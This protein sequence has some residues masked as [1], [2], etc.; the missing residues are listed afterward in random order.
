MASWNPA[1]MPNTAADS[2]PEPDTSESTSSLG[3]HDETLNPQSLV[4]N[5]VSHDLILD[6][7]NSHLHNHSRGATQSPTKDRQPPVEH[8]L[9]QASVASSS[10]E[11]HR[12]QQTDVAPTPA[13]AS[14]NNQSDADAPAPLANVAKH[15]SSVSFA[16]TVSHDVN[17]LDE[18]DGDWDLGQ[19]DTE[20]FNSLMPENERTNSFPPVPPQADSHQSELAD[21]PLAHSQ[22]EE[23]MNETDHQQEEPPPSAGAPDSGEN[24]TFLGG[25]APFAES[26]FEEGLPLMSQ[27]QNQPGIG[28]SFGDEE[29]EDFFNQIQDSTDG[30]SQAPHTAQHLERKSTMQA[31]GSSSISRGV[32]GAHAPATELAESEAS[33]EPTGAELAAKWAM[34]FANDDDFVLDG[35]KEADPSAFFGS[36]D[37][38]LLDDNASQE[39]PTAIAPA[40]AQT[41]NGRYTPANASLQQPPSASNIGFN[42]P[43]PSWHPQVPPPF[44]QQPPSVSQ[45][46]YLG[47]QN[48]PRQELP[49]AQSFV[50]KAKGGYHSPYDLPM[51]IVKPKK[52]A[53]AQQLK[54]TQAPVPAPPRSS[55]IGQQGPPQRRDSASSTSSF[56]G[57]PL[58]GK[59]PPTKHKESFFEELPVASRPRPASRHSL[60]SPSQT[61]PYAPPQASGQGPLHA[62]RQ[63][64]PH[65]LPSQSAYGPSPMGSP[66]KESFVPAVPNLVAP[67]RSDP[68]AQVHS[69]SQ[70]MMPPPAG[71]TSRYSPAPPQV[72]PA[73]GA[74]PP[75]SSSR[76]SP[77]PPGPKSHPPGYMHS[78]APILPHQPRTS[79]PLAHFETGSDKQQV[80][81]ATGNEVTAVR[82]NSSGYPHSVNRIP[83]LPPTREVDEEID[84]P[85]R[86]SNQ[87]SSLSSPTDSRHSPLG[88]AAHHSPPPHTAASQLLSPPKRGNYVPQALPGQSSDFVPP[89]RS[90]T[91]SPGA[92]YGN[93]S[94]E[95][96]SDPIPRPS[97]VHGSTSSRTASHAPGPPQTVSATAVPAAPSRPRGISQKFE[98]LPPNDGREQD[99]LQRWKGCPVFFWGVGGTLVTSF[100]QPVPRYGGV[101]SSRPTMIMSPGEVKVKSVKEVLP[102]ED[103]L[104]KFPGPLRG[105]SKK[106]ETIA[107]L[108]AGIDGLEI[109]LPGTSFQAHHAQDDKRSVERL[110]L[111]KILRVFVEHDGCLEGSEPIDKAVRDILA[112]G[113]HAEDSLLSP[114][115][116]NGRDMTTLQESAMSRMQSD[117]VDSSTVENIRNALLRGDREAAIWTAVDKRL[118]GH[119]MLLSRTM[120]SEFFVKVAQEFVRKEVNYPSHNNESLAALYGVLSGSFEEYVDELVPV[121]A[122]AGLQLMATDTVGPAK[123]AMEGLNKWRETLSLILSNRSPG[124]AQALVSLGNLL[125]GYGRAEASHICY[126]FARSA[127]AFGGLDDPASNFVLVGAD[128]RRQAHQF[129]NETEA[130][131]LSEVYEYGLSLAPGIIAGQMAPHLAAYKLVHAM[132]LAEH[133]HRDKAL[134]Y[135][136]AIFTSIGSQTRKSPYHHAALENAVEDL[137]KRLRQAPKEETNSWIPKPSMTKMSDSLF[138]KFNNFVS[139]DDNEQSGTGSPTEGAESGPFA[140]VAGGTPTISRSPSVTNFDP[141]SGPT[142]QPFPTSISA[143]HAMSAPPTR[144]TSRY[145]PAPTPSAGGPSTSYQHGASYTPSSRPSLERTSSEYSRGGYEPNGYAAAEPAATPSYGYTPESTNQSRQPSLSS[146][147]REASYQY[148]PA[149]SPNHD[150]STPF[151]Y[152]PMSPPTATA[153]PDCQG[154]ASEARAQSNYQAPSYGFSLPSMTPAAPEPEQGMDQSKEDGHEEPTPTS[155]YEPPSYGYEPPTYQPYQ[156]EGPDEDDKLKPKK[157]TIFDDDED[158]IPTLKQEKSKEEKDKENAERFR[159]AAEEDGKNPRP[160]ID[161]SILRCTNKHIAKRAEAEE[162]KKQSGGWMSRVFGFGGAKKDEGPVA[163]RAKLG[164]SNQFVFD[165]NLNRWINKKA[166]VDQSEAKSATPPPPRGGAARSVSGTPPP[167]ANGRASV[168]PPRSFTPTPS[169]LRTGNFGKSPS[170]DNLHAPPLM[171]RSASNTS[172]ASLPP[173]P[174]TSLSNASSIDDLIGPAAPRKGPKKARKAGR[175]VDVMAKN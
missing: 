78:G 123:D 48:P 154:A 39:P 107:W 171:M 146:A 1:L 65:G 94:T 105:K 67:P 7:G 125:S 8:H 144:A 118:W 38:G 13:S 97:S 70:P 142:P 92:L 161:A 95:K 81:T 62:P 4:E 119:A 72:P 43:S 69:S 162:A 138:K 158:D 74:M 90:H 106:K 109:E 129:A 84:I 134:Q 157:K 47:A 27:P 136:E 139:G 31:M 153:Q 41:T 18:E 132:T 80:S 79:S 45:S 5:Q 42:Q 85:S 120:P 12:A 35:G 101:S 34:E 148:Q 147:P 6:E 51:E 96:S 9:H 149:T 152:L 23:I 135:C 46:P 115:Y 111:W 93:R 99:P 104:A 77:A 33:N 103:R 54:P 22:A 116:R 113:L 127:V 59:K 17:W 156:P 172:T 40:P 53:S 89:R 150:T 68:Y 169:T 167:P 175:Y 52:R 122:R 14:V 75:A 25:D 30:P 71:S 15:A 19:N 137:M 28:D 140:R 164:E 159:K 29:G 66:P 174:T 58:P 76:Y 60:P 141:Y 56:G 10:P 64:I 44:A 26:R 86:P 100:P 55:S 36:D 166:G 130:L 82:S 173:R 128:H 124:D 170:K 63:Y 83:S 16:R 145:A 114:A 151:S 2:R 11:A 160:L 163:V 20:T 49:K 50:D 126:L 32:A 73:A 87:S 102:L 37:E 131:L 88:G 108:T 110:L 57:V 133:G 121:H 155:I 168:P 91:Q 165:P 24:Q 61:S 3:Q 143:T 112:P 98:L 21:R 117:A